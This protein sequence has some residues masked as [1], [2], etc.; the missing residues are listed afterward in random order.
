MAVDSDRPLR[1]GPSDGRRPPMRAATDGSENEASASLS[2]SLPD[3]V[4]PRQ[5]DSSKPR[6]RRRARRR[7]SGPAVRQILPGRV[8]L[9]LVAIDLLL[10]SFCIILIKLR[11][12]PLAATA[13]T[14]AV[15]LAGEIARRFLAGYPGSTSRRDVDDEVH[16]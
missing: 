7:V 8:L 9:T 6:Q 14:A 2:R 5:F 13:G 12:D 4:I 10:M 1:Q 15:V 11:Q 3:R 16:P